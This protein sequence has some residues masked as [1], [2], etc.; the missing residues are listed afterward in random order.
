MLEVKPSKGSRGEN[1]LCLNRLAV[2]VMQFIQT[3]QVTTFHEVA[4]MIVA[5]VAQTQNEPNGEK[6]TRRRVYDVL[7][8]FLASGLITKESK[9]IRYQPL[10]NISQETDLPP[11]MKELIQ[12]CE[13]KQ[14]KLVQ[15]IQLLLAYKSLMARNEKAMR[16]ANAIPM[17][18]IIVGFNSNIAGGSKAALNGRTLE[19]YASENPIFYSP[20]DVFSQLNFPVDLQKQLLREIPGLAASE[21]Y[22]F[23]NN[24]DTSEA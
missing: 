10:G 15:R 17:P 6:T 5:K 11:D 7:N 20:M 19:M 2:S 9:S 3:K 18:V 1:P 8:V 13:E 22:V 14:A 24:G 12:A 16:P 23:P 4:D 21:S